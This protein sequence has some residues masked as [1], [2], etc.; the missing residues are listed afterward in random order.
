MSHVFSKPSE[1]CNFF[2]LIPDP[3]HICDTNPALKPLELEIKDFERVFA[4][5]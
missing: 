5:V 2:G 4:S 3:P 1:P